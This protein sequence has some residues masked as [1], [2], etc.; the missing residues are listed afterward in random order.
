MKVIFGKIDFRYEKI[1]CISASCQSLLRNYSHVLI[2]IYRV[3]PRLCRAH[4]DNYR[5]IA[6]ILL[7]ILDFSLE[8]SINHIKVATATH[9]FIDVSIFLRVRR[10]RKRQETMNRRDEQTKM[11]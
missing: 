8:S 7:K 1:Y 2:I 9:G 10:D 6:I 4:G 11:R 5:R 3:Q